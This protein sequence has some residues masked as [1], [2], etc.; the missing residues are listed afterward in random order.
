MSWPDAF[1]P[2]DVA[3]LKAMKVGF[4]VTGQAHA[5]QRASAWRPWRAYAVLRLW[6][7]L[8]NVQ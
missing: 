1:P 5:E 7:S 8:E 6:K 3:L 2:G 4:G